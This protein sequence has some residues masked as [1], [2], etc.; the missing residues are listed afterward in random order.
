MAA[1]LSYAR[2]TTLCAEKQSPFDHT[3]AFN[4]ASKMPIITPM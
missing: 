2:V 1:A 4:I 3:N